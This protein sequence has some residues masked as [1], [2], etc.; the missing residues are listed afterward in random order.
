MSPPT[1]WWRAN[2]WWLAAL[3]LAAAAMTASSAYNVKEF[4]YEGGL[5]HR[6][7]SATLGEPV[8]VTEHYQ[9]PVYGKYLRKMIAA[10]R[11]PRFLFQFAFK[12]IMHTH[13]ATM[14]RAMVKG[15]SRLVNT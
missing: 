8:S 4:W 15:E 10:R 12:C 3:P 6:V 7:A 13:F 14:T 11:P 1:G 2:R 9:H 5:H